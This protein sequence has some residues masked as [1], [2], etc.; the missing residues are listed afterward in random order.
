MTI[1]ITN[2]TLGDTKAA[3]ITQAGVTVQVKEIELHNTGASANTV[4]LWS[5]NSGGSSLQFFKR[6]LAADENYKVYYSYPKE[7]NSTG[8][9]IEGSASTASEVNYTII[10]PSV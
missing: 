5:L 9:A 8:D 7:L 6:E 4:T 1:G 2:G 10:G 3:L